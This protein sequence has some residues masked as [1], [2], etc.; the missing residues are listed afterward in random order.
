MSLS[1]PQVR[2]IESQF[3]GRHLCRVD[4]AQLLREVQV[5]EKKKLQMVYTLLSLSVYLLLP[6]FYSDIALNKAL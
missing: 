1:T 6:I 2:E 5:Q 4:L 3:M